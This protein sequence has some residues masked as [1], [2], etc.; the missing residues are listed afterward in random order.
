[1][2][3]LASLGLLIFMTALILTRW[4]PVEVYR[5][6]AA[7][8]AVVVLVARI[9][10]RYSGPDLRLRRLVRIQF[11]SGLFFVAAAAMLFIPGATLRDFIALTLAAA[12]IQIITSIAIPARR[13]KLAKNG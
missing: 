4:T 5:W 3:G 2:D 9:F 10:T 7:C 13:K 11:W 12:V 6:V 8:G 1:M